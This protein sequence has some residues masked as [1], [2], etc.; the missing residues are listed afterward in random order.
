MFVNYVSTRSICSQELRVVASSQY[1]FLS[2][3]PVEETKNLLPGRFPRPQRAEKIH[4]ST[5]TPFANIMK[6]L[7]N[8][9]V[10]NIKSFKLKC[11]AFAQKVITDFHML[12]HVLP[13]V[14]QILTICLP[15]AL[16]S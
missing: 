13:F 14:L 7:K 3:R 2:H 6:V 8:I 4:L 10:Q 1:T 12:Y 9:R 15:I 5:E 11:W 16:P